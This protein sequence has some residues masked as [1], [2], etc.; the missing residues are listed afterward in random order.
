MQFET[1]FY[2]FVLELQQHIRMWYV[3]YLHT[4][5]VVVMFELAKEDLVG[6]DIQ[7]MDMFS[8]GYVQ[9]PWWFYENIC[10]VS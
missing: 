2:V 10:I 9:F 5:K 4:E 8:V 3:V 1:S 6:D 7:E